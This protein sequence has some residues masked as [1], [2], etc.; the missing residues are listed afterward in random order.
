MNRM[1]FVF[2]VLASLALVADGHLVRAGGGK[3]DDGK[4]AKKEGNKKGAAKHPHIVKAL[5]HL[6]D[7]HEQV[8]NAIRAEEGEGKVDPTIHRE[9]V[10]SMNDVNQAVAHARSAPQPG[11]DGGEQG[12][13]TA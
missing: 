7:A 12:Q 1:I 6:R 11:K 5:D 3:K 10:K 13:E 2:V 8:L 4:A 9:L